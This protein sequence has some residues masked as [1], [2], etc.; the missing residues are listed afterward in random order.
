MNLGRQI[1]QIR[2]L[3]ELSQEYLGNETGIGQ[4]GISRIENNEVSPCFNQLQKI[5]EVLQV[6]INLLLRFNLEEL[7]KELVKRCLDE[8]GVKSAF[9]SMMQRVTATVLT[10]TVLIT[11]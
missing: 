8:G 1:R 10:V 6:E 4:R 2:Q 5:A 11:T 7:I 3:R 9:R